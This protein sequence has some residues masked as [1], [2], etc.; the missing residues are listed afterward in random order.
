MVE[1][2]PEIADYNLCL[3]EYFSVPDDGSEDDYQIVTDIPIRGIAA[4]DEEKELRFVLTH[5]D[6]HSLEN[7]KDRIL[8]LLTDEEMK[9]EKGDE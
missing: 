5:S 8:K 4:H 7:S 3:S 2:N 9:R 6:M 1:E